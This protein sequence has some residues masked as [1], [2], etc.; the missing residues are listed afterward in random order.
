MGKKQIKISGVATKNA[1]KRISRGLTCESLRPAPLLVLQLG[2]AGEVEGD[3]DV[4]AIV[5]SEYVK[6][7]APG[8]QEESESEYV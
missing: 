7:L 4:L 3:L 2:L 8:D 6:T 1:R 5:N